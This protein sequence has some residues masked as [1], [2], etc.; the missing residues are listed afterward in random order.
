MSFSIAF[1]QALEIV[2]YVG[3]KQK[4]ERYEYLSI[5][6][7]SEKLNIPVPSIKRISSLLKK[8]G[9]LS[10]KPGIYGGLR[11]AKPASKITFYDILVTIEGTNQLFKVHKDFNVDVFQDQNKVKSWLQESSGVL[12]KAENA[13]LDVLKNTNLE[14]INKKSF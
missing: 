9:I 14:E 2:S 11:L 5:E 10:S 13:M 4:E 3:I 8:N 1:S 6:K 7:I 12:N